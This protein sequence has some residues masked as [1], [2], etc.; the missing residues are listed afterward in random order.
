MCTQN[1]ILLCKACKACKAEQLQVLF[2][3]E[4]G[5][6]G[7]WGMCGCRLTAGNLICSMPSMIF[8]Q[9]FQK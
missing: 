3:E 1:M 8:V 5:D 6:E 9:L 2:A 7:G 4:E